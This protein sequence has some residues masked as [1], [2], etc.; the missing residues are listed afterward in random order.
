MT[1]YSDAEYKQQLRRQFRRA[2]QQL[3]KSERLRAETCINRRLK[4][5]LKRGRRIAFYWPVGSELRLSGLMQAALERATHVYLPYIEAG[6][7][8]L[9]FTRYQPD[10][11]RSADW[12]RSASPAVST[13]TSSHSRASSSKGAKS[14]PA[15]SVGRGRRVIS[16]GPTLLRDPRHRIG[17]W[18]ATTSQ[19]GVPAT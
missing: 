5:L 11:R 9:W 2:R 6:K 8:R 16:T 10:T 4:K 14:G 1:G 3:P 7:R 13:R 17:A 19:S 15:G 18:A 12:P